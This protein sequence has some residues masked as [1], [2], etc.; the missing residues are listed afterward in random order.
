MLSH[1]KP[2][3][4]QSK[5]AMI[6]HQH[7]LAA[8]IARIEARAAS[9]GR[10]KL[11][12]EEI[13]EIEALMTA[14]AALTRDINRANDATLVAADTNGH[15]PG[16][17]LARGP[18]PSGGDNSIL[19]WRQVSHLVGLSRPTLWRMVKKGR[20]PKPIQLSSAA[21]VGWVEAEVRSWLATRIAQRDQQVPRPAPERRGRPRKAPRRQQPGTAADA[22]STSST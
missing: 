19:R 18:P 9:E 20:F 13:A 4:A 1:T 16:H 10:R 14:S 21:A 12:H 5:V 17:T 8:A 2:V 3:A 11:T 15:Y 6:A 22:A 7:A